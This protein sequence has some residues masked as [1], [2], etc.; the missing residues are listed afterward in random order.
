MIKYTA[1]VEC[2]FLMLKQAKHIL[3]LRF[4]SRDTV[5]QYFSQAFLIY[6]P[7]KEQWGFH[8]PYPA[9][10]TLYSTKAS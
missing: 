8:G 10:I 3:S 6:E 5:R 4:K 2:S 7:V 1:W 9:C